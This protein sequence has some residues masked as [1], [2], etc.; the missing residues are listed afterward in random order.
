MPWRPAAQLRFVIPVSAG[1]EKASLLARCGIF[2]TA[3]TSD[4]ALS[5]STEVSAAL[6]QILADA[7]RGASGVAVTPEAVII[8]HGACAQTGR[9]AS[10]LP[11]LPAA[12]PV[13]LSA[14][15]IATQA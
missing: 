11:H 10:A 12:A 8:T 5:L 9:V 7:I 2:G 3:N 4:A 13:D 1:A 14:C 6:A 15:C